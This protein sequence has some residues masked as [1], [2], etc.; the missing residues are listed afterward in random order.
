MCTCES[1]QSAYT[2]RCSDGH[3]GTGYILSFLLYFA[4]CSLH[5][6]LCSLHS[7]YNTI[8]FEPCTL[9]FIEY[10]AHQRLHT[11]QKLTTKTQTDAMHTVKVDT[12]TYFVWNYTILCIIISM[13]SDKGVNAES[14]LSRIDGCGGIWLWWGLQKY[15]KID[16]FLLFSSLLNTILPLCLFPAMCDRTRAASGRVRNKDLS[17]L[18]TS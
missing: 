5:I 4:Q 7:A 11:R 1:T 3:M 13:Y 9:K 2:T 17:I 8:F 14:R 16:F 18:R 10:I 6:A 15:L 12:K